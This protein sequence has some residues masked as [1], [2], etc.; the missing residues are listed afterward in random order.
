MK[1]IIK[2]TS[3]IL[4]FINILFPQENWQDFKNDKIKYYATLEESGVENFS[5]LISSSEYIHFIKEIADSTYYYPLKIIWLKEGKIYYVM[6]DFPPNLADSTQKD[7]ITKIEELKNL[8]KGTLP[9]WQQFSFFSPYKDIPDGAVVNFGKDTVSVSFRISEGEKS[10]LLKK[11]FT[12][13]GELARVIWSSGDAKIS[14]YPYFNEIENKWICQGWKNQFYRNG[15]VNSGLLVSLDL[16]K[17]E[18]V[19]LP[20]QFEIVAQTKNNPGQKSVIL[21]FLKNYIFNEKF[22]I[23][24]NPSEKPD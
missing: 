19:W 22:E 12:K 20:N 18:N 4:L 21:L 3:L 6:R 7:L 5:C 15:E 24:S 9:D 11:T 10:I 14:T 1:T 8:F 2:A 16:N 17:I 23:V 13:A